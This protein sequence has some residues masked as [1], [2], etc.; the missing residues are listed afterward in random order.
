MA[1]KRAE[2]DSVAQNILKNATALF[3]QNGFDAASVQ[4]IVDA[5]EV[6]KGAFYYYY[7]SKDELLFNI[8]ERFISYEVKQAEDILAEGLPPDE[9]LRRLVVGLV[10]SICLFQPEVTVFFREMHRLSPERFAAI[11]A[12][13]DRYQGFFQ[14]V[15][16][17][18]RELG[19]FRTDMPALL[20]TFATFGLCNW[21]YTWYR[22][23]GPLS[24]TEIGQNL[25][26]LLLGGMRPAQEAP[27]PAA[28]VPS[29]H[30]HAAAQP[31]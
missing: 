15:V 8:H 14:E 9:T 29:Q 13:R 11:K 19:E 2:Q 18:G 30:P 7:D 24:P 26:S 31:S 21:V 23:S 5:A 27:T 17:A 3:A 10:E 6:T 1:L 22:P 16:D 4:D 12:V 28:G 20:Q 25:A